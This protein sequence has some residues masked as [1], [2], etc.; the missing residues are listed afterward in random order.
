V[1]VRVHSK[2]AQVYLV[3]RDTG[4]GIAPEHLPHIFDRFYRVDPARMRTE[5]GNSGLGLAI[6]D[7]IVKAHGGS[8]A[9]ESQVGQGST[10]TVVFPLCAA[11]SP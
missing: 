11:S 4:I 2:N 1:R 5:G 9:V 7:W 8:I 6:V 10:F 3:V